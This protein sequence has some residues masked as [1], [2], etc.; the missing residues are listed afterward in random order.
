MGGLHP[1]EWAVGGSGSE[2]WMEGNGGRHPHPILTLSTPPP[3][4]LDYTFGVSAFITPRKHFRVSQACPWWALMVQ[5]VV[6]VYGERGIFVDGS[7]EVG[8]PPARTPTLTHLCLLPP[9][10]SAGIEA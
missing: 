2:A 8:A 5:G 3:D 10:Q 9:G 1:P 7:D 6:A 4:L